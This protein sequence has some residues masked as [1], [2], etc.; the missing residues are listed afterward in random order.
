MRYT[1]DSD[2]ESAIYQVCA[3]KFMAERAPGVGKHTLVLCLRDDGQTK[4]IFKTHIQQIRDF[5]EKHGRPK[6][7]AKSA[8]NEVVKPITEHQRWTEF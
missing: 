6:V 7:P 1:R 3:A 5:W 8:I 4:W 2:M